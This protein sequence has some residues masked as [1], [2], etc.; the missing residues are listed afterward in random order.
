MTCLYNKTVKD[1]LVGKSGNDV[2]ESGSS[3]ADSATDPGPAGLNWQD[4]IDGGD[5]IDE[6]MV[7]IR[8]L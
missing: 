7:P 3:P 5:G 4:Q 8:R 6:S 1:Y 2:L